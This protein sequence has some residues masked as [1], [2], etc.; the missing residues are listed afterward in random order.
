MS[1]TTP[2]DFREHIDFIVSALDTDHGYRQSSLS[3][4]ASENQ[5]S[6]A[7]R[8][9]ETVLAGSCYSFSPPFDDEDAE[10]YFPSNS[11]LDRLMRRLSESLGRQFHV[12]WVDPRPNGGSPCE[13]AVA[14]GLLNR[15]D[16]LFHVAHDGGGHF[17]LEPICADAGIRV[18]HVIYDQRGLQ[19][20]PDAT[21]RQVNADP[22]AKLVMLDISFLLRQQ[23]IQALRSALNEN[24]MLSVD[25]SHPMGLVAGG[26]FQSPAPE[27]ADIVHG[28]SH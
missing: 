6:R 16:T 12:S 3:L 13:H 15:G 1:G 21:A 22:N 5:P 26:K 10:W 28:N 11:G 19:I 8:A 2:N 24:V 20:D 14:L 9:A 27:G 17:A 7:V 25:I 4:I 18:S 23:P